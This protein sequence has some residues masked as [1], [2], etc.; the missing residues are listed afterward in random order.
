MTKGLVCAQ[1]LWIFA[2]S[3]GSLDE[4]NLP[5]KCHGNLIELMLYLDLKKKA[6]LFIRGFTW[7]ESTS[8]QIVNIFSVV[9]GY[10]DP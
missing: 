7:S 5:T 4:E 9:A 3:F 10:L 1:F 6:T 2:V 8:N